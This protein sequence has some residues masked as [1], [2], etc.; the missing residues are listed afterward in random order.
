MD[1]WVSKARTLPFTEVLKL[2]LSENV[3]EQLACNL[4]ED[5]CWQSLN[6]CVSFANKSRSANTITSNEVPESEMYQEIAHCM[7]KKI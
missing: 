4:H 6:P 1:I 2:E 5:K 3:A 7:Y